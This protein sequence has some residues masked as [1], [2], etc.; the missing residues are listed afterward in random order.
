MANYIVRQEFI[1]T[2]KEKEE[3]KREHAIYLN[4]QHIRREFIDGVDYTSLPRKVSN[5]TLM[6]L[7]K[8]WKSFFVAIKKYKKKPEMFLGR[9]K[10]PQYL[11]TKKGRFVATYE[12]GA[13]SSKY[14]KDGVIKLSGTNIEFPTKTKKEDICQVRI[15][16]RSNHYV[17]EVVYKKT[18]KQPIQS[19]IIASI[20]P[21][22]NNLATVAFNKKEVDSF[23]INGK[24]LKSINQFY[25]K[26]KAVM[27]SKVERESNKKTSKNIKKLT[28]KRNEK[29]RDYMHKSSAVLVNQLANNNTKTL[30]IGKNVGQKQDTNMGKKNNQNF[31]GIPTFKF[32]NMVEYKAKLKGIEVIWQEESYTSKA[33][34]FSNDTIPTYNKENENKHNFSGYREK[35]GL[36][37]M[38]GQK[39][40]INAD[41]NGALNILKKA[42]P[43]AFA[44]GIEGIAVCP[45]RMKYSV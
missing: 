31:V 16:P 36:Y 12:K 33:C 10:L 13:I 26:K 43:N 3:G 29:I 39:K 24:P 23:I 1:K 41:L 35:R 27:Q 9:P 11:D 7:D 8:N 2:S 38:K 30:V 34:F 40:Y 6:L 20:D 4:Y 15:V 44:D 21:G 19:D 25:N 17:I 18:E 5:Q 28:N 45:K 37:K 22:V 32:L 42:F 14:L